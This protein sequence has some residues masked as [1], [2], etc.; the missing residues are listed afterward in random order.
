[1]KEKDVHVLS[2][3]ETAQKNLLLLQAN[4]LAQGAVDNL[5]IVTSFLK[6]CNDTTNKRDLTSCF[7]AR[8]AHHLFIWLIILI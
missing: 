7:A 8:Y 6:D 4:R 1:M 2:I 3:V 5:T